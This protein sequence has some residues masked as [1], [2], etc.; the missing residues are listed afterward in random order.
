[1]VREKFIRKLMRNDLCTYIWGKNEK[2]SINEEAIVCKYHI[3][4]LTYDR[5]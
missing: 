1:M 3:D 4:Y 2:L 5:A